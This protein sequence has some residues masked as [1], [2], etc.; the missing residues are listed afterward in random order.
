MYYDV[1][2]VMLLGDDVAYQFVL[3][4]VVSYYILLAL[5]VLSLFLD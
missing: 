4:S 5:S 1:I 3:S 2:N